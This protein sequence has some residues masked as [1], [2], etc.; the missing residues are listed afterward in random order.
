MEVA[1]VSRVKFKA[2]DLNVPT[3]GG[4]STTVFSLAFRE[5]GTS[6]KAQVPLLASMGVVFLAKP[7][8]IILLRASRAAH[9]DVIG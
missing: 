4:T 5:G 7:A 2:Q 9:G 3:A 6:S 8:C 1:L